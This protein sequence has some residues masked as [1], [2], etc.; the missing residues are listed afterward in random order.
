MPKYEDENAMQD[1]HSNSLQSELIWIYVLNGWQFLQKTVTA[2]SIE[3][4]C[5]KA[6]SQFSCA[7]AVLRVIYLNIYSRNFFNAHSK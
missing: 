7:S 4:Y 6:F 5:S 1:Q 3:F 2:I